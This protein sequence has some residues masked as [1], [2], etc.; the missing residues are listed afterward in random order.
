MKGR[1]YSLLDHAIT[2]LDQGLQVLLHPQKFAARSLPG[3]TIVEANLSTKQRKQI[4]GLMRVNH[5]GEISAQ[6][7]YQGQ[8][9]TAR[10]SQIQAQM[11][12]AAQEEV[13]HLYWCAHRLRELESQPS[14]LNPLWYVGSFL[15]GTIAGIA[16]DSWSLGF[17]EETEQQVLKHI[18]SHL[19]QLPET[20][21]KTEAILKQMYIDEAH[22]A[23]NANAA[24]AKTL[25]LPIKLMMKGMSKVMTITAYWI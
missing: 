3:E 6:A 21:Q 5:A 23:D 9:L 4:A 2:R 12:Q 24:G 15:I 11:K 13:D 7:L 18:E 22:H 17:V 16:G 19:Q 10:N 14:L 8:G 25:P 1:Q 20:D